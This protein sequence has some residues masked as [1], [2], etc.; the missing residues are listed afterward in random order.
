[1]NASKEL[2][3]S[4]LKAELRNT[5]LINGLNAAGALVENFYTDLA[6]DIFQLIG[7]QDSERDDELYDFYYNMLESLT[8]QETDDFLEDLHKLSLELYNEL[9]LERIRRQKIVLQEA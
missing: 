8:E 5:K 3:T 2:I 1:M 6:T 7:F 4:L 9:L